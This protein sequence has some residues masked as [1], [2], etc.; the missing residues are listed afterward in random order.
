MFLAGC[1]NTAKFTNQI[2]Q[3][4]SRAKETLI[5]DRAKCEYQTVC[6]E[7]AGGRSP[8]IKVLEYSIRGYF[9]KKYMQLI[10]YYNKNSMSYVYIHIYTN[11][12]K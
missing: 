2:S 9:L 1:F 4:E 8:R 12:Y 5:A 7:R 10:L 6:S 11:T 3:L